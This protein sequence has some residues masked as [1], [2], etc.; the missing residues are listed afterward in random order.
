VVISNGVLN[1]DVSS[2]N[3]MPANNLVVTNGSLSLNLSLTT[4]GI[5]ANG[6]LTFQNNATNIFNYGTVTTNP[7]NPAIKTFGGISA[8][9]STVVIQ[10]TATGLKPG[11]FT[12]IKYT[13]TTLPNITNFQ[14]S[15]P[16]GVGGILINNTGNH[17]IDLQITSIPNLLAWNGVNGTS[18]DLTT[19]N[20]TNTIAGGITVFQ[21]YTNNGVVA[22][23]SVTFDDTLTNDFVNPQPTNITLNARFYAFPVLYNSTLPYSISGTGGILGVTSLTVSN[24]GSLTMLTSNSFSG[25]VNIIGTTLVITNDSALG[26][27]SGAVTL[28][29]GTLQ[30]NGGVTN[31]RAISMPVA[32]T[33]GVSTN[34]TASLGG[35]ISGAGASFNKSDNG[36]L[37]LTGRETF[38]GD[39]FLHG[40][41]TTI[42]SGGSITNG[43]YDDVGQ[44]GSDAATLTLNGT[45]SLST[46]SDFNVGDL[47]SSIGTLNVAGSA[48]LTMN[49][50][51]IGSANASGSTAMG[52]VNQSGGTITEVSTGIGVFCIG[53]RTSASAVG[54][55]NMSGGTLTANAGIRVGSTGIGTL[56]QSGGTINAIQGINIARI[57]GSYGTN[58]LNGGTLSTYDVASSTGVNA[59]FNFNGGTLQANF[60]P[61]TT[62]WF[63]GGIQANILAGGAIIDSSNNNVTISTPLLAGSAGGGLTKKGTGTL[64]LTGVNTFTGPITNTAGTLYLNSASTYSGVAVAN[65]GNL[66]LTTASTLAGGAII[67]TNAVLTINQVGSAT[68]SLGNL[69]FNGT[70][71]L[72]GGT[73]ALAPTV[74]N[75]PAVALVSCGTLTLNGTNTISVPLETVGTL[76]LIHYSAISGTG[77]C[78]NLALPQGATGY[79]SNN[80]PNST[81]YAVITGTG[82]G[83]VWTGTNSAAATTNLWDISTT[84]NWLLGSTATTYHQ[85]VIPGDSVTFNDIGSGTVLVSN[86]V[87]PTSLV[88]SNNTKTYTFNGTAGIT[89]P[90][91]LLKLGTGTTIL[92]LTNDTY[93]GNTTI[94]NGILQVASSPSGPSLSP[95]ANLVIGPNGTLQLSSQL[96]NNIETVGEFTGSGTINYTGG[97]NSILSFGGSIGGTWNGNIHSSGGAGLSLT[98]NGTGTWIVG[99]TNLLINGDAYNAI[100]QAQFNQGTTIITNGGLMSMA[101]TEC[102]IAYNAGSTST[103]VVAGGTLAV[104]NNWLRVGDNDP[105]AQGTLIVNS[106]QVINAGPDNIDVGANGATGTLIVNGG[107]VLND[108]QLWLGDG[109]GAN[110]T[111]YLNGGLLQ[112]TQVV[113]NASPATSIAYFNGGTLQAS[114]SS[115]SLLQV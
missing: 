51:F 53:G 86:N 21:Q 32:S 31:S 56:N 96:A 101:Y 16:P 97:I 100:S 110:G 13:G 61:L 88:I 74:A 40:G 33:I 113:A 36:T 4:N 43:S 78:T 46:T 59:V 15:P 63:S 80:A 93:T 57:A 94:S 37:I 98:K 109:S 72:P 103:V 104:S 19:P 87:G 22:G 107:Q 115:A 54:V 82:P 41:F 71:A 24:T 85:V 55:Y 7:T 18:W 75:N 9:G 28:N 76:A 12:L 92:N 11:T 81:L 10:I 3:P 35:V 17:S 105:T 50:F 23:D 1:V 111:L 44:N 95:N 27:S 25:G 2:G 70:A 65:G 26:A 48:T 102:W 29:G 52:T 62:T 108:G 20:W 84:P 73:L 83:I 8:P 90:T 68:E 91:G 6:N 106:G 69:T 14:L 77:N 30:I 34:N 47:D 67:G 89:G 5:V 79:I 58:N 114:A 60:S 42:G 112:A 99:G 64:T 49:A 66:E 39:L 38:T 45:G